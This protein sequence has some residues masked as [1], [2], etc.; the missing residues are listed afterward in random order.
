[1]TEAV[2][3]QT[4]NR[5]TCTRLSSCGCGLKMS[6]QVRIEG[7]EAKRRRSHLCLLV[8]SAPCTN[9]Q[10]GQ[11]MFQKLDLDSALEAHG[12]EVFLKEKTS[13]KISSV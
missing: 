7:G 2:V 6:E 5:E 12:K 10:A 13:V 1:M 11:V 8:S 9:S 3:F 4:K